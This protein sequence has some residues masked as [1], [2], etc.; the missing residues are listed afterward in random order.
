MV[1]FWLGA[2]D[3]ML[4][5]FLSALDPF[6]SWASEVDAEYPDELGDGV[7]NLIRDI[8]NQ[9]AHV[10]RATDRDQASKIDRMIDDFY[11]AFCDYGPGK[12]LVVDTP[13]SGAVRV[14]WYGG[15]TDVLRCAGADSET[16]RLWNFLIEG[17][18]VLRNPEALPYISDGGFF[19][20]DYWTFA[21]CSRLLPQLKLASECDASNIRR[22][23]SCSPS[24]SAWGVRYSWDEFGPR[25]LKGSN[26]CWNALLITIKACEQAIEE[27]VGIIIVVS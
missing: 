18:P 22:S 5:H 13:S 2:E 26:L 19:S 9:G 1:S 25:G 4:S 10:L 11:G 3:G 16:L 17:R 8:Q 24:F 27:K 12:E 20:L 21:E 14:Q 15:A 6:E 23:D 7:L